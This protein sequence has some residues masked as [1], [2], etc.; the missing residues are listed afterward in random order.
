MGRLRAHETVATAEAIG[1]A[2]IVRPP[3]ARTSGAMFSSSSLIS[4][5]TRKWPSAVSTAC[6]QSM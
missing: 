6:L 2:P 3:T 5:P 4:V 1:S